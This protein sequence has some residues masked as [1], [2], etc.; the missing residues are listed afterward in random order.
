MKLL[1]HYLELS[2]HELIEWIIDLRIILKWQ[3]YVLN[4]LINLLIDYWERCHA[5][6]EEV[7]MILWNWFKWPIPHSLI[8]V[9]CLTFDYILYWVFLRGKML[10]NKSK[11]RNEGNKENVNTARLPLANARGKLAC[12]ML[13]MLVCRLLKRTL[14]LASGE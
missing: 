13:Y 2:I 5:R 14:F 10:G 8:F 3:N 9:F 4:I 12:K 6:V 7:C 11:Q 1:F